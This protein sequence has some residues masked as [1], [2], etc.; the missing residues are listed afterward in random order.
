MSYYSQ[1]SNFG[2]ACP[3][4]APAIAANNDVTVNTGSASQG[5]VRVSYT[6]PLTTGI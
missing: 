3:D 6:R 2:G 5:I 1:C 4:T